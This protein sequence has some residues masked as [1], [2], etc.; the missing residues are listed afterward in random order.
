MRAQQRG[1]SLNSP[2]KKVFT[3]KKDWAIAGSVGLVA[4]VFRYID[5]FGKRKLSMYS[6]EHFYAAVIRELM[7]IWEGSSEF[8]MLELW[9]RHPFLVLVPAFITW[10]TKSDPIF[11]A[12]SVQFCVQVSL[13]PLSY[14]FLRLLGIQRSIAVG[15]LGVLLVLPELRDKSF[16]MLPDVQAAWGMIGVLVGVLW[17]RQTRSTSAVTLTLLFATVAV[18]TK[19]F[20]L[21]AIAPILAWVGLMAYLEGRLEKNDLGYWGAIAVAIWGCVAL[22]SVLTLWPPSWPI[23]A[24]LG[25][26][27]PDQMLLSASAGGL[28]GA[29]EYQ[30]LIVDQFLVGVKNNLFDF[31]G[32]ISL[33]SRA[34]HVNTIPAIFMA[35]FLVSMWDDGARAFLA[36]RKPDK[37]RER[38]RRWKLVVFLALCVFN[39][40]LMALALWSSGLEGSW[41]LSLL[42]VITG[43]VLSFLWRSQNPVVQPEEALQ[44]EGLILP[45]LVFA[46][47]LLLG[48]NLWNISGFVRFFLPV[49]PLLAYW[50]ARPVLAPRPRGNLTIMGVCFGLGLL[51]RTDLLAFYMCEV[52]LVWKYY[53]TCCLHTDNQHTPNRK[54]LQASIGLC[55]LA[56]LLFIPLHPFRYQTQM[57]FRYPYATLKYDYLNAMSVWASGRV[58]SEDVIVGNEG[59]RTIHALGTGMSGHKRYVSIENEDIQKRVVV[60][61]PYAQLPFDFIICVTPAPD[62]SLPLDNTRKQFFDIHRRLRQSP[63]LRELYLAYDKQ[64][65][66]AV[67][68]FLNTQSPAARRFPAQE[69]YVDGQEYQ[70][71][72]FSIKE[73][74]TVRISE[75]N[76][77]SFSARTALVPYAQHFGVVW[78]DDREGRRVFFRQIGLDGTLLGPEMPLTSTENVSEA[79][80]MIWRD[81]SY[82]VAWDE[83]HDTH[84]DI[85]VSKVTIDRER[86]RIEPYLR[87]H[88]EGMSFTG[89]RLL[90]MDRTIG[91]VMRGYSVS[92]GWGIYQAVLPPEGDTNAISLSRI[93]L[94]VT[95]PLHVVAADDHEKAV[96]VWTDRVGEQVRVKL[97]LWP[98][99]NTK[100]PQI[101]NLGQMNEAAGAPALVGTPE[102]YLVAWPDSETGVTWRQITITEGQDTPRITTGQIP[103]AWSTRN[104]ALGASAVGTIA[105]WDA[106]DSDRS[107]V[108]F[109]RYANG[110][111]TSPVLLNRDRKSD[112]VNPLVVGGEDR[113]AIVWEDLY[114]GWTEIAATV[115]DQDGQ[116]VLPRPY[117]N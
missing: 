29:M 59:N 11:V 39:G 2:L 112:C 105:V 93:P 87:V 60:P 83:R 71:Q 97:T 51:I 32:H 102:G 12:R 111:W 67:F 19:E 95:T 98:N 48:M 78:T 35:L 109:S 44:E 99:D 101:L 77:I 25:F 17:W 13:F 36:L 9:I 74:N 100:A 33:I 65:L 91:V 69:T 114:W 88:E 23:M 41:R 86:P 81:S 22:G 15:A 47:M 66:P 116:I 58:R 52:C 106:K 92:H 70:E 89:A 80:D 8:S 55:V 30:V 28:I 110:Q 50:I 42:C 31:A 53:Q 103:F 10:I 85:I 62:R 16:I 57:F 76:G 5:Y 3:G 37:W 94:N 34:F 107:H 63:V 38:R 117:G 90:R 21:G 27:A 84:V 49:Y 75:A 113:V 108:W 45:H 82:H 43:S 24:A 7:A 4:F 14:V 104:V 26:S 72:F 54:R 64:G 20:V 73:N 40:G 6:D 61:P 56:T 18:L 115:A 68:V 96:L 1:N 79:T 46:L